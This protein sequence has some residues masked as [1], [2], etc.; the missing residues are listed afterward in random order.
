[1]T[2]LIRHVD[3]CPGLSIIYVDYLSCP[4]FVISILCPSVL[5]ASFCRYPQNMKRLH[6]CKGFIFPVVACAGTKLSHRQSAGQ[7]DVDTLR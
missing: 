7:G 1:M 5:S 4:I 3:V 6:F 2:A